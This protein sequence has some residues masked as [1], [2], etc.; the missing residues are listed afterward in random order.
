MALRL[1]KKVALA[2]AD[3]PLDEV[4][5]DRKMRA[6]SA[7]DRAARAFILF[8]PAKGIRQRLSQLHVERV[9]RLWEIQS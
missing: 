2:G 1:I 6:A 7:Q 4:C 5:P 3:A 8:N 9:A